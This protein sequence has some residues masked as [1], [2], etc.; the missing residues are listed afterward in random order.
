MYIST[1]PAKASDKSCVR[2]RVQLLSG[3]GE[4]F[5]D[6]GIVRDIEMLPWDTLAELHWWIM[7]AFGFDDDHLWEFYFGPRRPYVRSGRISRGEAVDGYENTERT[8]WDVA[9][10]DLPLAP[11]KTF[12]HVFD[13]GDSWWFKISVAKLKAPLTEG[14]KYPRVVERI[15]KSPAQYPCYEEDEGW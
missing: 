12:Y 2:L 1:A 13:F 11:R 7:L 8:A 3:R 5:K 6:E 4:D 14:A 9:L 15:G 10:K